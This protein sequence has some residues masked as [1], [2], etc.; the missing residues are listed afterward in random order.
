MRVMRTSAASLA[1]VLALGLFP[2]EAAEVA[3]VSLPAAAP[4]PMFAFAAPRAVPALSAWAAPTAAGL[5]AL[6]APSALVLSAAAP[7]AAPEAERIAAPADA[8]FAGPPSAAAALRGLA[9]PR[10][11][12]DAGRGFDGGGAR[13]A[14]ADEPVRAEIAPSGAAPRLEKPVPS[15]PKQKPAR[16]LAARFL[17]AAAVG[18]AAGALAPALWSAVPPV[19]ALIWFAAAIAPV[20]AAAALVL[21][22]RAARAGY[23]RLARAAPLPA[24][25]PPSRRS[26]LA[27]RAL[28]F[29]VGLAL[30][31]ATGLNE[32]PL[33]ETTHVLMDSRLPAEKRELMTEIPPGFFAAEVA[34]VLSETPEGRAALDRVRGRDGVPRMPVF[35]VT[36]A[37][38]TAV[39]LPGTFFAE[40]AQRLL[41]RTLEGRGV[42]DGL[43]DRGGVVRMPIFFVSYQEGSAARYTPP[44]A[45]YLSV[46]SIEGGGTTVEKFMSDPRAQLDFIEREQALLVHELKHADQARRSPFGSDGRT[47]LETNASRLLAAAQDYARGEKEERPAAAE[48][49][50][51]A[52]PRAAAPEVSAAPVSLD[53][54]A[55]RRSGLTVA[56][57]LRDRK[58]QAEYIAAHQDELARALRPIAARPV[59]APAAAPAARA[60]F[61]FELGMIQEWEYEAH[62]T[63]HLYTHERLRADP[64]AAMS[65]EELSGY[66]FGLQDFD[67]FLRAIDGAEIYSANFHSR[68]AYYAR[69]LADARAGWDA[70]RVEGYVLLARRA[71]AEHDLA[72]AR[73]RLAQA[74]SVAAEKGLPAPELSLPAR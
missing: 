71:L 1:A 56:E 37:R 15:A 18:T 74:R 10:A 38:P 51:A 73:A 36:E 26:V 55:I 42:L 47:F 65:R 9:A 39:A 17:A 44:D 7:A 35:T 58:A 45:V 67:S 43:R 59:S 49:P 70:R 14:A 6:S 13:S 68:S 40:A 11:A 69:Y 27:V 32:R 66:E 34:R 19:G 28:G 24:K 62:I 64:A 5:A 8:A 12:F 25:A 33:I 41:A 48:P 60:P 61:R 20:A 54:G 31:A 3:R 46:A 4:L 16:S 29:A 57:F 22:A 21:A 52:A 50:A 53:A 23:R 63:E 30:V 2:A 72:A